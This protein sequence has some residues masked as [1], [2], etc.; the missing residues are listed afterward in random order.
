V[1]KSQVMPGRGDCDVREG[2]R[3]GGRAGVQKVKEGP[4]RDGDKETNRDSLLSVPVLS[5][6][7]QQEIQ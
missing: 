4:E 3:E 7:K 1:V 5:K 2:G 6:M